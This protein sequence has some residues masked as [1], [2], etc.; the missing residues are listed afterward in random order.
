MIADEGLLRTLVILTNLLLDGEARERVI[1]MRRV[2]RKYGQH[3]A[4][5]ST[6]G[7]K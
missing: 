1:A 6:V 7:R 4:A 2:C 3:L 5:I